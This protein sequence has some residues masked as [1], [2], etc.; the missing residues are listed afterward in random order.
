MS[1]RKLDIDWVGWLNA[2]QEIY[3]PPFILGEEGEELKMKT[4]TVT[5]SPLIIL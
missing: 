2:N 5:T 4:K 1:M 3:D